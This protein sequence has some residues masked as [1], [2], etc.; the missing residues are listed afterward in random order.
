M[1]MDSI[2]TA[3]RINTVKLPDWPCKNNKKMD[4]KDQ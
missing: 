2:M 4:K 3:P 1:E